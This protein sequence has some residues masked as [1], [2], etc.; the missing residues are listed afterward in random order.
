MG[1]SIFIDTF[2]RGYHIYDLFCFLGKKG[3]IEGIKENNLR[4]TTN[5][6][7]EVW[8]QV[9]YILLCMD[10][11]FMIHYNFFWGGGGK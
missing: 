7:I 6:F 11:I 4:R 8:I 3:E 5:V 10:I 2:M 1:M 9:E